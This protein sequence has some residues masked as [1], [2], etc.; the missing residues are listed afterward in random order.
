MDEK[1]LRGWCIPGLTPRCCCCWGSRPL[2]AG[3][4]VTA[5]PDFQFTLFCVLGKL[6][7]D[8]S[9]FSDPAACYHASPA[10]MGSP[11]GTI[12]QIN[13][14]LYKLPWS[15][16]FIT[17]T[18]NTTLGTAIHPCN[19]EHWGGRGRI[20]A[21]ISFLTTRW[22]WGRLSYTRLWLCFLKK[23][24]FPWRNESCR[25]RD[26]VGKA[27]Q[28]PG[29]Q[30]PACREKDSEEQG[31]AAREER[32]GDH[33]WHLGWL[34]NVKGSL[35]PTSTS[36]LLVFSMV[37]AYLTILCTLSSVLKIQQKEGVLASCCTQLRR[38]M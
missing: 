31:G 6:T 4:E 32:T 14:S 24:Q 22:V 18:K 11:S 30:A 28:G 3:L 29:T 2:G 37:L 9:T 36:H 35:L 33:G 10:I 16:H 23:S 26:H 25:A 19:S 15:W 1:L 13:F 21:S 27:Q 12:T 8:I 38:V 20:G 5:L 7:C 17:V 34:G